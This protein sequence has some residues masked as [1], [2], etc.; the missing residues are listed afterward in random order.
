VLPPVSTLPPMAPTPAPIAVSLSRVVISPQPARPSSTVAATALTAN[1]RIDFM[2]ILLSQTIVIKHSRLADYR[3]GPTEA[4]LGF[5]GTDGLLTRPADTLI[6]L[7]LRFLSNKRNDREI[8]LTICVAT[9]NAR[10]TNRAHRQAQD[11]LAS[12]PAGDRKLPRPAFT[13][14]CKYW[15]PPR[16]HKIDKNQQAQR[17]V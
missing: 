8:P 11:D 3:L 5:L 6:R 10:T 17:M 15:I 1:L 16:E 7:N 14:T 9:A 2:A 4:H 12:M 13:D